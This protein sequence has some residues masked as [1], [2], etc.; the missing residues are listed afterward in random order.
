MGPRIIKW[1]K[2]YTTLRFPRKREKVRMCWNDQE[3]QVKEVELEQGP[4]GHLWFFEV[5]RKKGDSSR[6]HGNVQN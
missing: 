3:A 1:Q 6:R 2:E 5:E 4:E